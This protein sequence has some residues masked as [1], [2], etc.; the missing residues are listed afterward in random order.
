MDWERIESARARARFLL[1]IP[2]FVIA[3]LAFA[4]ASALHGPS[5]MFEGRIGVLGIPIDTLTLAVG[6][7]GVLAGFAW[8]WWIYRA[9]MK[10][11]GAHWHFHDH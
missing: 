6:A 9:P 10:V 11:E 4:D 1:A 2:W 3:F 5:P 8:M 7:F